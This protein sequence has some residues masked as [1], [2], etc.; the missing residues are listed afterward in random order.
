MEKKHNLSALCHYFQDS[1]FSG[2][3]LFMH[4]REKKKISAYTTLRA[5]LLHPPSPPCNPA[6]YTH[7]HT[8][9]RIAKIE[10]TTST[11]CWQGCGA[12]GTHSL[13]LRSPWKTVR[14]FLTKWNILLLYDPAITLQGVYPK[15]L[16][17]YTCVKTCI[18][19]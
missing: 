17:N 16:K 7:T 5:K 15:K 2:M 10:N 4:L 8:P 3:L 14:Q 1:F 13:L 6:T 19:S 18:Q 9:I 11:Q 12:T